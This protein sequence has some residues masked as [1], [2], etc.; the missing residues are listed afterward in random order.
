VPRRTNAELM[1]WANDH[2]LYEIS[3]VAGHVA[4]FIRLRDLL[5]A[6]PGDPYAKEVHDWVGRNADIES[7]ALHMRTLIDFFFAGGAPTAAGFFEVESDWPSRLRP[8]RKPDALRVTKQRVGA[9]IAHL[10][11]VRTSPAKEWPYERMWSDLVP[12]IRLFIE[13]ASQDRLSREFCQAVEVLLPPSE[14]PTEMREFMVGLRWTATA[15]GATLGP[16]Y[17]LSDDGHTGQSSHGGTA[18]YPVVPEVPGL[19]D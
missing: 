12:V 14:E 8:R 6:N 3:M 2:L 16:P 1:A 10:S 4:R 5:A 18:T 19:G 9:E 17:P 7:F 13:N 15:I 11:F